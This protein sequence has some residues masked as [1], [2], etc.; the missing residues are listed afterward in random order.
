MVDIVASYH[1][2]SYSE[3]FTIY[4]VEDFDTVKM[5]NAN[6]SKIIGVGDMQIK[7]N[8]S[9]TMVSKDVEQVHDLQLNFKFRDSPWL[10][11]LW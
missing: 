11:R 3:L 5:E 2:T 6:I 1:A 8:T 10:A 7:T 4:K 9:C